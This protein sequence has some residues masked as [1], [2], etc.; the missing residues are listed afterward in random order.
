MIA[1]LGVSSLW[2]YRI[3]SSLTERRLL[4]VCNSTTRK[5][6]ICEEQ[7]GL[8][9]AHEVCKVSPRDFILL[10]SLIGQHESIVNKGGGSEGLGSII[11][12]SIWTQCPPIFK[13]FG[14]NTRSIVHLQ[15]S[16]L[17]FVTCYLEI[18]DQELR[19]FLSNALN[20]NQDNE[21]VWHCWMPRTS[22]NNPLPMDA[23]LSLSL[24]WQWHG[25][26]NI[27]SHLLKVQTTPGRCIGTGHV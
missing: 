1:K 23:E 15:D 26:R 2:S 12:P 24:S 18:L 20:V 25:A 7:A 17:I 27:I 5:R 14:C 4:C 16:T 10:G 22:Q 3:W 8:K 9:M 19:N 13:P 21:L 11:E 6:F